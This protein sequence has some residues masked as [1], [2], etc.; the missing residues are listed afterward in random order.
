MTVAI[1]VEKLSKAYQIGQIGSGTVSRDLERWWTTKIMGREDPFLKLGEI[2]DRSVKGKTDVVWS[3]K[4]IDLE[5]EQGDALG[6]IG[7][8]GAG[9]STLLKLL[10][11]VTAPST[12]RISIKGRVASLLEVGTGFHPELTGRENIYLNGSILGM[13]KK[14]IDRKL[15]EIISFSGVERY[16]DTPVKRYSSGMSVRLAFAVAAQ[17]VDVSLHGHQIDHAT[18]V[19]LFADGQFEW[20]DGA[21][22]GIGQRFQDAVGV[23]AVAIHAAGHDQARRLIFLAVVPYPLGDHLNAGDTVHNNNRGID[24]GQHQLGFMNEHVE[25]RRV[26]DIDLG[27]APLDVGKAGGNGHLA[28]DFFLVVIGDRSAVVHAPQALVGARR[29][30]HGGNQR[31]FA[32]VS[33]SNHR[34]IPDVRAF[35][36]L[37]RFAP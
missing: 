33:V 20:D 26:H 34:Y 21:S 5:I 18:E 2:N 27:L 11:R 17:F 7:R 31:G 15:D 30:Q 4:D 36:S 19:F 24:H 35:V 14:E 8:N 3:L 37:H 29:I 1:R 23:G 22:E 9:K 13:R 25:A 28:G 12:G 6:I 16:V 32:C 10:S